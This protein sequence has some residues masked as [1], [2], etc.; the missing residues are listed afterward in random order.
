MRV[1]MCVLFVIAAQAMNDFVFGA[2]TS[3]IYDFWLYQFCDFY[4]ELIKPLMNG[5]AASAASAGGDLATAQRLSR[6]TLYVCLD[7]GLRMLHPFM[8]FLTE[9]LWQ[10]LPGR[11][12]AWRASGEVA[13]PKSIMI[14]PWPKPIANLSRPDIEAQFTQYQSVLRAGRAL[15][16]DADIPP[17]KEAA[18]TIVTTDAQR[19]AL[20]DQARDFATLLRA[21]SLK[22]VSSQSEVEE[23]CSVAVVN[24]SISVHLMLKGLID[25]SAEIEKL[26]KRA[27]NVQKEIDRINKKMNSPN[28]KERSP[29]EVQAADAEALKSAHKQLEVLTTLKAQY[30]AWLAK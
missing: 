15:R 8:P 21:G 3:A 6:F 26:T 9:E 19:A 20:E 14:T 1:R 24:D 5:D 23:G 4:L 16:N 7:H 27:N 11:G 12:L 30:D 2:A 17:S 18:F 10:R 22:F 25:P 28:Y 13:D 29:E